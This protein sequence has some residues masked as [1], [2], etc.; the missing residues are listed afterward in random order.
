MSGK[1]FPAM[2]V[3]AAMGGTGV[4]ETEDDVGWSEWLTDAQDVTVRT[5]VT[6]A[7]EPIHFNGML[8]S[9]AAASRVRNVR[10]GREEHGSHRTTF[11]R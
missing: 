6:A 4:D 7:Q 1:V 3:V 8:T 2:T 10:T 5:A 9:L 11:G